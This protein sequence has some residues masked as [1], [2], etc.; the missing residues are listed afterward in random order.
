MARKP[1]RGRVVPNHSSFMIG[2]QRGGRKCQGRKRR[3]AFLTGSLDVGFQSEH[4]CSKL[5]VVP[6]LGAADDAVDLL[7]FPHIDAETDKTAGTIAFR[8]A[9]AVADV[10]AK[11]EA[12]PA[13][14][15]HGRRRRIDRP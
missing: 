6:G 3:A 13:I 5:I 7:G 2:G 1:R 10:A 11:V 14:D 8:L 15:R 12:G 4:P 9:P